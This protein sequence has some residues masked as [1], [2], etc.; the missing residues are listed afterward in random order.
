MDGNNEL[1]PAGRAIVFSGVV[2]GL[3]AGGT[4]CFLLPVGIVPGV[5]LGMAGPV[6]GMAI[7]RP[8]AK[9]LARRKD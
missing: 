4:A 2:M 5:L 6:L 7:A 1:S 8:I 9:A 3:I